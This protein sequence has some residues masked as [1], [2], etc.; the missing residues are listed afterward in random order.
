MAPRSQVDVPSALPQPKLNPGA[1]PAAGVARSRTTASGTLPPSAQTLTVHWAGLPRSL[2]F[3]SR[4]S[5]RQ[6]LAGAVPAVVV[7]AV[8]AAAVVAAT[9]TAAVVVV[10]LG[11]AS[12]LA[13]FAV[14]VGESD[15]VAGP[16]S[17]AVPEG[18]AVAS[19]ELVPDGDAVASGDLVAEGAVLARGNVLADGEVSADGEIFAVGVAVAEGF[20]VRVGAAIGVSEGPALGLA[21]PDRPGPV[22]GVTLDDGVGGLLGGVAGACSSSQERVLACVVRLAADAVAPA[23]VTTAAEAA[24]SSTPPATRAALAGCACA[25][26]MK[27]PYP[28][29]S[30]LLRNDSVSTQ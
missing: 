5:L 21:E 15:G 22:V 27:T 8:V 16:D 6:R 29:C 3:C 10:A 17:N 11:A 7:P 4:A 2:L 26:R 14:A 24:V 13:W 19:G 9:V 25:K 23:L 1:S 28:C 20:S 30:L 12:A 18:D